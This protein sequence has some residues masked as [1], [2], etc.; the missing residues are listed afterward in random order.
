MAR[1]MHAEA[2]ILKRQFMKTKAFV[3]IWIVSA[4][5]LCY[6]SGG[7][8]SAKR[9]GVQRPSASLSVQSATPVGAGSTTSVPASMNLSVAV[10][11]SASWPEPLLY[12][13]VG[14]ALIGISLATKHVSRIRK[15]SL[16]MRKLSEI[17]DLKVLALASPKHAG[18]SLE[19]GRRNHRDSRVAQ[20]G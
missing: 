13:L 15:S 12:I 9:I 20:E 1:G 8:L 19:H 2:E 17:S 16:Q 4:A 5:I 11:D 14:V 10:P 7:L 18:S 3:V 6:A